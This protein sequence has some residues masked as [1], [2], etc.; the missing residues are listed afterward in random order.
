MSLLQTL[1]MPKQALLLLLAAAYC[2]HPPHCCAGCRMVTAMGGAAGCQGHVWLHAGPLG[3]VAGQASLGLQVLA[4][5]L[6][7]LLLQVLLHMTPRPPA[8]VQVLLCLLCWQVCLG[9]VVAHPLGPRQ[10]GCPPL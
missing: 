5:R 1:Q 10:S 3:V 6:P 8:R 7:W 9:L 2:W 4:H